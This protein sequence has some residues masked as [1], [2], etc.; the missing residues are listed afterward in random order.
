MC[1]FVYGAGHVW[2]RNKK[3]NRRIAIRV[4]MDQIAEDLSVTLSGVCG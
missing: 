1:L 4:K 3:V 2:V